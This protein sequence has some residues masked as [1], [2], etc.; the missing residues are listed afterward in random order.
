[1]TG[2]TGVIP[3]ATRELDGQNIEHRMIVSATGKPVNKLT[4]DEYL[5]DR[6]EALRGG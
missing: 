6:D 2:I 4:V 3:A 1:M 5:A